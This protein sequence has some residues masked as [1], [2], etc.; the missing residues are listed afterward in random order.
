MTQSVEASAGTKLPL[1]VKLTGSAMGI[2][3]TGFGMSRFLSA[4]PMREVFI[5]IVTG[6][7]MI[8]V[9]GYERRLFLNTEGFCRETSFWGQSK[10]DFVSWDDVADVRVILNKGKKIYVLPHA[11]REAWPL[12][13]SIEQKD[14][15]LCL[16]KECIAEEDIKIEQ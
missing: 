15:V 10:R 7:I 12:T 5:P 1:W 2:L 3:F 8:Y 11:V 9:S 16:L 4:G 6:A 14:E 13:F